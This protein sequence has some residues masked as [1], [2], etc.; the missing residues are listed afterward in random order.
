VRRIEF[1]RWGAAGVVLCVFAVMRLWQEV[2]SSKLGVHLD[3]GRRLSRGLLRRRE[4][5]RA[6]VEEERGGQE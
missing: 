3:V 5:P 2:G 1:D 4:A 6:V